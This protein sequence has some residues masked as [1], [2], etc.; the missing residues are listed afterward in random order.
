[1]PRN[2]VDVTREIASICDEDITK[3]LLKLF[4]KHEAVPY[5]TLNCRTLPYLIVQSSQGE[6]MLAMGIRNCSM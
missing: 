2:F 1:M 6:Y 3:K 4:E 5:M